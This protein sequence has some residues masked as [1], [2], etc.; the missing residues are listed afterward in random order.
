MFL[1][2][3]RCALKR[4]ELRLRGKKPMETLKPR[5]QDRLKYEQNI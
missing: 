2:H 5:V 3:N 4:L 1:N